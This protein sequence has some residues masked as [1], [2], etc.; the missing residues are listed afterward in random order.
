VA[1]IA[2]AGQVIEAGLRCVRHG[3]RA[4]EDVL[5]YKLLTPDS[6][7]V[8]AGEVRPGESAAVRYEVRKTGLHVFEL[9]SGWN[10]A[11][12]QVKDLPYAVVVSDHLSMQTVKKCEKLHFYVPKGTKY[13]NVYASA[14]VTGEGVLFRI[15]DSDGEVV[16]EQDGDLDKRTKLQ[17]VLRRHQG[18]D[19]K[20]WSLAILPPQKPGLALDDVKV[21]FD[22]RLAPY[23]AEKPE[24]AL[25]FGKRRHP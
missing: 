1:V 18:Q 16:H 11:T 12:I 24:W 13:F 23:L 22:H 3:Y 7:E 10:L 25:A 4:Y 17:T 14:S 5:K 15:C 9:S 2:E 6:D 21:S 20:V 19:G 8:L